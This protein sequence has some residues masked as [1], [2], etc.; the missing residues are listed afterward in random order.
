MDAGTQAQFDEI[1][2]RS[3]EMERRWNDAHEKAMARMDRM[4]AED[5]R[6]F[7][8]WERK[9][10]AAMESWERKHAAA[11]VRMD[12]FE[13][14]LEG[15]RKMMLA[16][17]KMMAGMQEDTRNLKRAQEAFLKAFRNGKNGGNGH[18]R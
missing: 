11:M 5:Q 7:K 15:M 12:K 13:R 2:A 10:A 14:S 4:E 8:A 16:G 3:A 6:K 9:H 18:K 1:W 17:M